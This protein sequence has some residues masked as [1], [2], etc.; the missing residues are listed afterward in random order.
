MLYPVTLLYWYDIAGLGSCVIAAPAAI[1]E[2][3]AYAKI[4]RSRK[5]GLNFL[6][7]FY[8]SVISEL[9]SGL[10]FIMDLIRIE[11]VFAAV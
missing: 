4:E 7:Y 11:R 5:L 2:A 3:C 9:E 1:G 6:L 10:S 8:V